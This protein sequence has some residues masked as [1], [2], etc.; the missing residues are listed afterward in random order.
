L[1]ISG[2]PDDQ[3]GYLFPGANKAEM[4]K[5]TLWAAGVTIHGIVT[6]F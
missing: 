2:W 1:E 4:R 5:P 6:R 3:A